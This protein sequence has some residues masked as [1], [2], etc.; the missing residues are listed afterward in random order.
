MGKVSTVAKRKVSAR[1]I[2]AMAKRYL[3][4]HQPSAYK[5][6]VDETPELQADGCW[7]VY[8]H[9]S[10]PSVMGYEYDGRIAQAT[11]DM[12]ESEEINVL[13]LDFEPPEDD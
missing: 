3:E 1:Q 4:P 10:D 12:Q 11:V 5:L 8:V 13:M 7:Y 6:I 2:A 9:P